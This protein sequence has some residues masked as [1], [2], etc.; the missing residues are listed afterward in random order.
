MASSSAL[1]VAG[2]LAELPAERRVVI[3]TLRDL[4]NRNL[5]AGYVESMSCGMIAWS[6][7]LSRYPVTYNGQPLMCLALAAQKRNFAL[8]SMVLYGDP[9]QLEWFR[10]EFR[11]AGLRLDMG[12]SCVRFSSLDAL[13]LPAIAGLAAS[14]SVA[15]FIERYEAARVPARKPGRRAAVSARK[16]ARRPAGGVARKAR[17]RA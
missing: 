14:V 1:T 4:V 7:P 10:G 8:Y 13:P 16:D 6:V 17:P 3:R 9:G 11:K 15:K 5:P 12:K 2:Y